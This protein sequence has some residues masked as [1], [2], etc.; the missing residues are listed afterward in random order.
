MH[1]KQDQKQLDMR[2]INCTYFKLE[3]NRSIKMNKN[4]FINVTGDKF[5]M[6]IR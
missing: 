2:R 5:T 4:I 3:A 1:P 6:I